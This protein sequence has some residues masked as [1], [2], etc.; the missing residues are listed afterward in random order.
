MDNIIKCPQCGSAKF[1]KI[2]VKNY[3]CKYCGASFSHECPKKEKV[4]IQ[5]VVQQP[6]EKKTVVQQVIQQP[7]VE[8]TVV[9]QVIQQ[10]VVVS[11][12]RNKVVAG[13]LAIFLGI[14]GIH[15]FYLGQ[16]IWGIIYLLFCWTYIP[17]WIGLAEGVIY[18][19]MSNEDF[20]EKDNQKS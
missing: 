19:L 3:E 16:T 10:Q 20:D 18:L 8:K 12:G 5:S 11:K 13:L 4:V 1:E 2:G 9:Q 7:K 6:K 14:L 15:K 17:F